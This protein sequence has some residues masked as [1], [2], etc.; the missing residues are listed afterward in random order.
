MAL[1]NP[2]TTIF[3]MFIILSVPWV[4]LSQRIPTTKRNTAT[5]HH[6]IRKLLHDGVGNRLL[7]SPLCSSFV[8]LLNVINNVVEEADKPRLHII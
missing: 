2:N 8:I 4:R 1:N 7:D 6:H 3:L 5:T